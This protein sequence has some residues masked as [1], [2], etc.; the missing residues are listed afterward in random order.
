M[1][2]KEGVVAQDGLIDESL[3]NARF[4]VQLD[5][6]QVV[7]AYVSGNMRQHRIRVLPGD[8]VT[9]EFSLYDLEKGRITRRLT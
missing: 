4:R 3:P 6:G 2:E 9:V 1:S 5:N 8:R 7:V